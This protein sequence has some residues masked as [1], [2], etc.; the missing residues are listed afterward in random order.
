MLLRGPAPGLPGPAV[1]L[2]GE[3]WVISNLLKCETWRTNDVDSSFVRP[4]ESKLCL[5][6]RP[7]R[8]ISRVPADRSLSGKWGAE[9]ACQKR[10][11]REQHLSLSTLLADSNGSDPANKSLHQ[12]SFSLLLLVFLSKERERGDDVG[13][14]TR[15]NHRRVKKERK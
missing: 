1:H 6:S 13:P 2:Q 8:S 12:G 10:R 11:E 7:G 15:Q 14:T 3:T 9:L 4:L 5:F